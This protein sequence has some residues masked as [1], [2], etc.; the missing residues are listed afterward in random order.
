MSKKTNLNK[1]IV[2]CRFSYLHCFEPHS[3]NGDEPRYG[4]CAIV[5][6]SEVKT[7]EAIE[8]AIEHAK[9]EAIIKWG[10]IPDYIKTPLRDGEMDFPDNEVYEGCYFFNARSVDAPQVVNAKVQPILDRKEVYSGCYGRISVTFY[11]YC[12]NSVYGI[13]AGLG[14]I[15]KIKDGEVISNRVDAAEEF[16][17]VEDF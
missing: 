9:Q 11:S 1:V 17:I 5:P 12:I 16:G 10:Y 3:I 15:Q 7:L 6:K 4:L 2:P 13:A 14:N 8:K